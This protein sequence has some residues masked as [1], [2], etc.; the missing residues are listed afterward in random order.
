MIFADFAAGAVLITLGGNLSFSKLNEFLVISCIEVIGYSLNEVLGFFILKASDTGGSMIIHT[1]GAVFGVTYGLLNRPRDDQGK[2][3]Y[4]HPDAE[5]SYATNTHAFIGTLFLY[6]FW[7][8]FNS[9]PSLI[10]LGQSR[11]VICT[12]LSLTGSCIVTFLLSFCIRR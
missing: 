7:P 1:F 2:I 12:I 3:I 10:D 8:S 4:S 9:A 11:S 5:G 6:I